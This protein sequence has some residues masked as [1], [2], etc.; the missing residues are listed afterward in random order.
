ML[1]AVLPWAFTGVSAE[2][3]DEAGDITKARI[4][5]DLADL[6]LALNQQLLGVFDAPAVEHMQD[7]PAHLLLKAGLQSPE[8]YAGSVG[9]VTYSDGCPEVLEDKPQG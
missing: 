1:P 7:R 6:L 9:D 4:S 2:S 3:A 5:G 8:R